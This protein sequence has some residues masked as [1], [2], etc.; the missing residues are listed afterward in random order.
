MP[1]AR[2]A[3]CT[4]LSCVRMSMQYWSSSTMRC[5]PRTCPSIRRSR[6]CSAF[7]FIS[8]PYTTATSH[9]SL[10]IREREEVHRVGAEPSH[11]ARRTEQV[12]G[13]VVLPGRRR[14]AS[15]HGHATHRI[16]HPSPP[17]HPR[18]ARAA[19]HRGVSCEPSPGGRGRRCMLG[20]RCEE[21]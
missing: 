14:G 1:T 15:L 16:L 6:S 12:R 11:A 18:T 20:A 7:L 17:H 19:Y 2:R 3:A 10:V 8:Y 13:A 5:S 4:E 9:R 21:A